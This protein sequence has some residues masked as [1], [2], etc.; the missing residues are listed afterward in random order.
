VKNETSFF[1]QV[2]TA[3]HQ[4]LDNKEINY[5]AEDFLLAIS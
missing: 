1:I 3:S 5:K 2:R 4:A